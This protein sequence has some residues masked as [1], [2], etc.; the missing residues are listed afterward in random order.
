MSHLLLRRYANGYAPIFT[1]A[2]STYIRNINRYLVPW[3]SRRYIME[4]ILN[5]GYQHR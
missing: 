1:S 4:T 2:F 5:L 3:F